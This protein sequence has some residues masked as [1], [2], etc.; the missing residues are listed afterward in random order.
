MLELSSQQ[1][2]DRFEST[3]K[4]KKKGFSQSQVEFGQMMLSNLIGGIGFFHGKQIVD[5]AMENQEELSPVDYSSDLEEEDDDYF[6]D[7]EDSASSK[8][9]PNPQPEGP[10][11][12]FTAVPSRPFFPRGFQ[13]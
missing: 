9:K 8:I 11:S 10:Y 13:W 2:S 7:D 5:R 4:L 12:L 3:Y 6:N 1:F